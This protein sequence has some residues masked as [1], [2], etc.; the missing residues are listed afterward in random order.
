[1]IVAKQVADLITFARALIAVYLVWI[2][3]VRGADSLTL[4]AWVMIVNWIGDIL[5]G[6]IARRSRVQ[7]HTWIGDKDMEVD[8]AV[9]TG[10]LVYM[11]GAGFVGIWTTSVYILIWGVYFLRQGGIPSSFGMLFQ[12]PIYGWFIWV[13]LRDAPQAGWAIIIFIGC[14]VALTWPH[15]PN[16]MV[17]GFLQGLRSKQSK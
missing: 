10:L 7:Y 5:D 6:R 4:I 12:A 11:L 1:M 17:T 3:I 13:A 2:G 8:M 9:S 15:F 16:V 14:A